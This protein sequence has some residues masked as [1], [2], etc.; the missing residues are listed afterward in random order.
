MGGSLFTGLLLNEERENSDPRNGTVRPFLD[1]PVGG[2]PGSVPRLNNPPPVLIP[3]PA[4]AA[5]AVGRVVGGGLG[6]PGQNLLKNPPVWCPSGLPSSCVVAITGACRS[7]MLGT[8]S[9]AYG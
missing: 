5:D 4:E 1:C 6:V 8:L 9:R 2:L 3:L 7:L